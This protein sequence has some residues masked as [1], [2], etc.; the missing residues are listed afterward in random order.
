MKILKYISTLILLTMLLCICTFAKTHKT[1]IIPT[2]TIEYTL[3]EKDSL[4][5]EL[6]VDEDGLYNVKV[7]SLTSTDF[8]P[9]INI[10]L[11]QKGKEIYTYHLKKTLGEF[12]EEE[13]E[14]Y[15][16]V[17]G[18]TSGEYKV[19]I[20]NLTKFSSLSFRI[21]TTFSKEE[22][23]ETPNNNSF[24]NA[25]PLQLSSK[26]YGGITMADEK[27]YFSFEMPYDGYAFIEMYS[28]QLKFFYLFDENKNEIGSIGIEIEESDKI[29]ELRTGLAKGKYYILIS[30]DEDYTSPLYTIKVKAETNDSAEK[31]YNNVNKNATNIEADKEYQGNLFGTDD[32]D[33][34]T[35]SLPEDSRITIDFTDTIVS[36][37][38]HYQ[39]SLSDGENI[40]FSDDNCGRK[41]ETLTLH[42]GTYYFTVSGL[43]Y[44]YF[45]SMAYKIKFSSDV[46]FVSTPIKDEKEE[47]PEATQFSDVNDNSWYAK[48]LLTAR[49]EGLIEGLDGNIYNPSGNVTIAQ[50]ITMAARL[51]SDIKDVV[52]D[53][54]TNGSKWYTPYVDFAIG[55]GLIEKSDFQNF[56][57]PATRA[58]VAHIF[59]SL[60]PNIQSREIIRLPDVNENTKY[61]IDIY[62]L[63]R[64]G[65]LKG[66]DISGTFFP[67][68]NISRAETAVILLR[69]FNTLK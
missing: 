17:V 32:K 55:K 48:D 59:S 39:I 62:K 24:E 11:S 6:F 50:A 8:T 10:I 23:I 51:Y 16:F 38:G 63:Y 9:E 43:G 52:I 21:E 5:C 46:Q 1:D 67:D 64:I 7:I 61:H 20:Q 14:H 35:F 31:E 12:Q 2:D 28:P 30:N 22:N 68:N 18:L 53:T 15:E 26:Y 4:S 56:E 27:D 19:E 13:P 45:T 33:I 37:E 65:I 54:N 69:I 40:L 57:K 47:L 44:K 3:N 41:S 34:F 29:Y 49:K 60:F 42:K 25:T 36:K 58:E 66:N